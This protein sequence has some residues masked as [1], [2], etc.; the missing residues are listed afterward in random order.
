MPVEPRLPIVLCDVMGTLVHDPFFDAVPAFFG[1]GLPELLR[2]KTPGVWMEFERG[3]IDENELAARYFT[4]GRSVDLDGL[5]RCMADAYRWLPGM[6]SLLAELHGTGIPLHAFSNYPVWYRLIEERLGLSEF[7]A[8]SFVSCDLG[9]R[10][11]E[12]E[13]YQ[14]VLDTLGVAPRHCLLIDDREENCSA[15]RAHGLHA[16]R[17]F[18]A[19][20]LR[21]ALRTRGLL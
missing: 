16:E 3:R 15:A 21:G 9:A 13:A 12:A 20:S 6:R 7:L 11:P 14:R 4:D 2:T 5:K 17:F 18:D 19:P 1:M 10:K 8:W